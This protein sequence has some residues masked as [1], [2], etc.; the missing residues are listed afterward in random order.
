[1][2]RRI[3]RPRLTLAAAGVLLL[4]LLAWFAL[5][6]L[7]RVREVRAEVRVAEAELREAY[8]VVQALA[9]LDGGHLPSAAEIDDALASIQAAEVHLE[10]A[11]ARL[12]YLP[13]L[14]PLVGWLPPTRHAGEVPALLDVGR[15]VT[16][17]ASDLLVAVLPLLRDT[18][19][20]D[21]IGEEASVA[22]RARL[23]FVERGDDLDA[24]L[25]RLEAI[26]P[27]V[28]RLAALGW[29]RWLDAA[30]EALDLLDGALEEV[31]R[32][33]ELFAA[34][35]DG[36]DPL[37]GF[38]RP[39]TYLVAGLNEGELRATGGFMGTIGVLTVERGRIVASEYERVY[40]FERELPEY[41]APPDDLAVTMGAGRWLLRDAN[42]WP[43]FPTSAESVL[44]LFED[45]QGVRADGVI[46]INTLLTGRLVEVFAPIDL[47]EYPETMTAEGWRGVM[48]RTLLEGREEVTSAD[49]SA[50]EAYLHPLME[51]LIDR[52]QSASEDQ[53]PALF[54][55]LA[56]GSA[57]RDLQA[58]VRDEPAQAML[59]AVGVTGRLQPL[60]DGE[61][62][63]AV[64]DSNV[65]WSKVQP[66]VSRDTTVL[67]R[68]DGFVDIVV[69]WRNR[70]GALDPM[71]YPRAAAYGRI[72]DSVSQTAEPSDGVF[73]N[74]VR[75]YLPEGAAGIHVEGG[76]RHRLSFEG[77][78]TVIGAIV[79]VEDG[80]DATLVVTYRTEA[81]PGA[82]TVWKQ[83]GQ[84]HDTLRLF[85]NHA[86]GQDLRFDGAFTSDVTVELGDAPVEP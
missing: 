24:S 7:G 22:Q 50:E 23:V 43:D 3:L 62:V 84:E 2:I 4:I 19:E 66:G 42:W 5:S 16:A 11:E 54:A 1:M 15:E 68:D 46:A 18:P 30:P 69:R 44:D 47:P 81:V 78:F 76:R 20:V 29:G 79:V 67:V 77:G 74:Y 10:R 71:T 25:E 35:R 72:Y 13:A 48:E 14:F 80:Q 12:G 86:G 21:A 82:V 58:Y 28:E 40:S 37:L 38:D 73:G 59:D 70:A 57:S 51:H 83:G 60:E 31:P 26:T 75:V 52:S 36:L 53:L 63:I 27:E 85:H 61:A 9:A 32:A 17:S 64:V 34:I 49:P 39:R 55:A 33:R 41:P 8:T 6:T 56:A 45:H 65:S